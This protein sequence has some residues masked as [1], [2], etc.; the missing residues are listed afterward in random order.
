LLFSGPDGAHMAV[1]LDT[2]ARLEELPVSQVE[3]TGARWVAQY[4]GQILPLINLAYAL[5]E[6][7]T[8]RR[9]NEFQAAAKVERYQVLVCNH[10]GYRAGL[11]VERIVDIVEDSAEVQY[12]ASRA[13]VLYSA[14]I[15]GRVTEM[16]DVPAIL[17]TAHLEPE[18][19]EVFH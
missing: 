19:A 2:L 10:E 16:I 14:V 17:Q 18:H 12:P 4:R 6:R 8:R 11:V 5:Q 9:S 3:K 15:Q 1:P 7:R 13:G